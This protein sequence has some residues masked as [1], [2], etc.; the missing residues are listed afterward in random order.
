MGFTVQEK[1]AVIREWYQQY[2]RAGNK[3]KTGI[4]GEAARLTGLNRKYLLHLPANQGETT[5]VRFDGKTVRLK[6]APG[7]TRNKR[8]GKVIY[9]QEAASSLKAIWAYFG[10]TSG[11]LPWNDRKPRFFETDT[12][13][14]CGDRESGEFNL[15]LDCTDVY[16]GW[17]FLS[18]L[19]NKAPK[20]VFQSLASLP[21]SIP[22][23]LL[24]L[25]SG[26]GDEFISQW[27]REWYEERLIRLTRSR[28]YHKNDNC[29][30]TSGP[31]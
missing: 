16:S 14:H 9:G 24:G 4:L 7:K 21:Q 27:L 3:E 8:T 26:N 5:T 29:L 18:S 20:W 1:Q 12:V 6:A 25:D 17:V 22:F 2:Q 23:P 10:F 13:H 11:Q 31:S 30:R 19:L 15:T 28:P